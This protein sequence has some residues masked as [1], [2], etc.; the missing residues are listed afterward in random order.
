VIVI[1]ASALAK[2]VLA[3]EGWEEVKALLAEGAVSVD[4]VVKEVANALWRKARVLK[5]EDEG[6]ARR[7]L[8]LLSRLIE[9][10]VVKLV[11]ELDYVDRAFEIALEHGVTVYDALYIA[12]AL[13]EGLPLVTCDERQYKASRSLGV[14]AL[15]IR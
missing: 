15:L 7:R 14:E 3:E 13:E 4:H 10:G 6:V 12:L 5:L 9:G 1:D 2:Y 11:S 8:R